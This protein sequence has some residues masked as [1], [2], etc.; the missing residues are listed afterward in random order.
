M[1]VECLLGATERNM[2]RPPTGTVVR[3]VRRLDRQ[4]LTALLV[5]LYRESGHDVRVSEGMVIARRGESTT[6]L[7]P[8][9]GQQDD[10]PVGG[11]RAVSAVVTTGDGS[12]RARDLSEQ[13]GADLRTAADLVEMLF[14]AVDRE[15]TVRLCEEFLGRPPGAMRAPPVRR[16]RNRLAALGTNPPVRALGVVLVLA[17]C[18]ATVAVAL[19]ASPE[20]SSV[21]GTP[22]PDGPPGTADTSPTP[23]GESP[24]SGEPTPTPSRPPG[25]GSDGS[26][27]VWTLAVAHRRVLRTT[28]FRLERRYTG[29]E[30]ERGTVV[31]NRTS[32]YQLVAVSDGTH[33][34]RWRTAR[35]DGPET[36]RE[37]Y[38][39]GTRLYEVRYNGTDRTAGRIS[40][41]GNEIYPR[42]A[43]TSAT[44]VRRH[45]DAPTVTARPVPDDSTGRYRIVA[46]GR[47]ADMLLP[48]AT[49]YTARA[50]VRPSGVVER[51]RVTY[52]TDGR[53]VNA[54][55]SHSFVFEPPDVPPWYREL[56]D[57]SDGNGTVG[58]DGGDVTGTPF[59]EQIET[60]AETETKT[61]GEPTGSNESLKT[62]P[63]LD[64]CRSVPGRA[65]ATRL[66]NGASNP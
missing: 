22:T 54:S 66:E 34:A 43:E 15:A 58:A 7:L 63:A 59:S 62:V 51:L 50:L 48:P 23:V 5:A 24:G 65:R 30:V 21:D 28:D 16:L 2:S 4:E 12:G 27:D 31:G 18:V 64:C 44:V 46:R 60:V 29:P 17:V 26:V 6:V 61:C 19:P 45:L 41:E 13:L 20:G 57:T 14:Y 32:Q 25:V 55:L 38:F 3:Y 9:A 35:C 49:N 52:R 11:E 10:P 53:E 56:A 36:A 47:P 37:R 33:F 42:A 1:S 40:L 39:D 8:V